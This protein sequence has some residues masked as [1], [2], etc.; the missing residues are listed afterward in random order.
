M[1]TVLVV[2]DDFRVAQV[3]ATFVA[4]VPGMDVVGVTHTA[5]D[6]LSMATEFQPDLVLLDNYLPDGVGVE[7]A[8]QLSADIFMVTADSSA[9]TIRAAFAAGALNYLIKPFTAEQLT[10]RLR[11]YTRYRDALPDGTGEIT[12]QRIDRAMEALHSADRPPTPKGQSEVT[13]RLVTE[14]L[15]NAVEPQSAADIADRLGIARAT[16]QRYLAAL[17][18]DR[19]ATMSLRYGSTGRPE[20]QYI[21]TRPGRR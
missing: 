5:A 12:Q 20:H 2:D 14:A 6:T 16:A 8:A 3:H 13:A 4:Q 15:Q 11:A 7:I 19:R 18:D 9:A 17:A 10:T 1:I 21:W